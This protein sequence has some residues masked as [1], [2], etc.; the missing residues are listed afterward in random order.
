MENF[1]PSGRL[2]L[3]D[4]LYPSIYTQR[5]QY[6]IENVRHLLEKIEMFDAEIYVLSHEPPLSKEDFMG[7]I[8]LL[9]LICDLTD[10]HQGNHANLVN[11]LFT[12]LNRNLSQLE[13]E[14]IYC[15]TG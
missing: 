11:E 12:Q 5:P 9:K 6:K 2:F 3:G 15:F 4:C 8:M 10:K 7:Y 1:S 13:E 14:L